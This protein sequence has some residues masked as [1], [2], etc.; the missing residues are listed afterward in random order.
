[1]ASYA[2]HTLMGSQPAAGA[3]VMQACGSEQS[4]VAAASWLHA[5]KPA[6][7]LFATVPDATGHRRPPRTP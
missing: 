4:I 7:R 1:M 3:R 5:T 6:T 2:A